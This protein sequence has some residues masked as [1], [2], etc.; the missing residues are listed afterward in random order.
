M[1][2]A[3]SGT[4]ACNI[5]QLGL[6]GRRLT[7]QVRGI[8]HPSW[9]VT[10]ESA[11]WG[12]PAKGYFAAG[13]G[14][15]DAAPGSSCI[16]AMCCL[17]TRRAELVN[18]WRAQKSSI[19]ISSAQATT[20]IRGSHS[21]PCCNCMLCISA[22]TSS[23]ITDTDRACTTSWTLPCF[24]HI[25]QQRHIL[26]H[27]LKRHGGIPSLRAL[28]WAGRLCSRITLLEVL[29]AWIAWIAHQACT[30]F[31][32]TGPLASMSSSSWGFKDVQLG[33]LCHHQRIFISRPLRHTSVSPQAS[34]KGPCYGSAH[35]AYHVHS[36]K[37]SE[38][39][40]TML[41]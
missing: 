20:S 30:F 9:C 19:L 36:G 22:S 35:K 31:R 25:T 15:A 32:K 5:L 27:L 8:E 1:H 23:G 21:E 28:Q 41:P 16:E 29:A 40:A 37:C 17:R 39:W 38:L 3:A 12:W 7:S 34:H 6:E 18:A 11:Q 4:G 26:G 2:P 33:N 24:S 14:A 13:V 10:V